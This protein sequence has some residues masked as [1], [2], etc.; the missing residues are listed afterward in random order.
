[1]LN[2]CRVKEPYFVGLG[3]AFW[4]SSIYLGPSVLP[5]FELELYASVH[6]QS[7]VFR[8][9]KQ[10][11]PKDDRISYDHDLKKKIKLLNLEMSL[12]KWKINGFH[13]HILPIDLEFRIPIQNYTIFFHS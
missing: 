5:R 12:G 8:K 11:V 2:T 9:G 13:I 4:V 1:M 3:P 6:K 10:F 7:S